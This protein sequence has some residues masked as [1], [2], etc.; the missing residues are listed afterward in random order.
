MMIRKAMNKDS[1]IL[2]E[3]AYK[4]KA[5]WGYPKEFLERCKDDLTVTAKYLEQNLVYVMEKNYEI[6]AFY[7][8]SV[9]EKKL[10]ALFIHPEYIGKGLG[11]VL[12][13]DLL[14]KAKQLH[15]EELMIDS[16]PYAEAFYLKM[17]AKRIGEIQSTVFTDRHLPLLCVKVDLVENTF[18]VLEDRDMRGKRC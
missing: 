18:Q 5:Y 7:S 2:S 17:G 10:D 1:K 8:I 6:I 11:R 3:L 16:D 9:S 13:L 12:W 14:R 15:M 4:S